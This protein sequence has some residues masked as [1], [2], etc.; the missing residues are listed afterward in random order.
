MKLQNRESF[1]IS[2]ALMNLLCDCFIGSTGYYVIL[3]INFGDEILSDRMTTSLAPSILANERKLVDI[4][5]A[6]TS[7]ETTLHWQNLIPLQTAIYCS[8]KK[9]SAEANI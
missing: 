4:N 2:G 8:K 3:V 9:R 5:Q 1:S 6:T 7:I